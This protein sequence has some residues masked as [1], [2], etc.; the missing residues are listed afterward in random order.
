MILLLH[1]QYHQLSFEKFIKLQVVTLLVCGTKQ[2][3]ASVKFQKGVEKVND[4]SI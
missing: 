4:I 3:N 2:L 1:I